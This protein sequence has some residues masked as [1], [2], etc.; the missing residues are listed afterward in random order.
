MICKIGHVDN[1]RCQA[2][3]VRKIRVNTKPTLGVVGVAGG[4]LSQGT[5]ENWGSSHFLE[6]HIVK[7][8]HLCNIPHILSKRT[9]V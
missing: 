5:E 1:M 6:T 2:E 7:Q 8:H 9:C 4:A 3:I